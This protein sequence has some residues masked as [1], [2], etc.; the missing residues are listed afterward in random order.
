MASSVRIIQ[1][2][3]VTVIICTLIFSFTSAGGDYDY[4]PQ[5]GPLGKHP[6]EGNEDHGHEGFNED[7][8]HEGFNEDHGHEGGEEDHGHEGGQEDAGVSADPTHIVDGALVCFHGKNQIYN[9]CDES[10]RL[11]A[12]G[13]LHVPH[14][15]VDEFCSGPCL[16]ETN[17]MLD[18][19]DGIMGHFLFFNRATT[20]D[21]RDTI[22]AGCGHGDKRGNF[23]VGEHIEADEGSGSIG[24][25]ATYSLLSGIFLSAIG[26]NLLLL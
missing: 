18:C 4:E 3:L 13:E 19:I 1:Y 12:H 20:Q 11:T 14:D 2:L 17:H 6:D 21:V 24:C 15:H 22:L 26:Q 7:H 23:D 9:H 5:I 25:K 10:C 16:E 8:G